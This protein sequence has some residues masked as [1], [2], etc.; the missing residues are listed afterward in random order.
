MCNCRKKQNAPAATEPAAPAAEEKP[1]RS[2]ACPY[3]LR[4]HLLKARGYA[5]EIAEEPGREWELEKLLENLL[6]A[7]DHAEALGDDA[8]RGEIRGVRLDFEAGASAP[9]QPLLDRAREMISKPT[10][11]TTQPT[12]EGDTNGN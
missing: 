10:N 4:K 3:C 1:A 6:L 7:E 8:L 12:E 5:A 11:H 2:G 9:V